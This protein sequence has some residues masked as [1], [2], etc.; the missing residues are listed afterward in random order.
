M[1]MHALPVGGGILCLSS[2]P[3]RGGD[4]RGDLEHMSHWR[5]AMVISLVT[6]VELVEAGAQALG[7]HIQDKGT[8]WVQLSIPT[9]EEPSARVRERW[10]QVAAQA[11]RALLGGGR[12]LV[13]SAHGGGRCGMVAL[14]LMIETGEAKDEALARLRAICPECEGNTGQT[15]WSLKAERGAVRFVRHPER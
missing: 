2:L 8:R 4:Y 15:N 1:V 14:R 6:E 12:V 10:P 9:G 11:Q 7:Q 13:H 3:G 5:P